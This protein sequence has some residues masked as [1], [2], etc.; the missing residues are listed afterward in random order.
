M[1][2]R[3]AVPTLSPAALVL[4]CCAL[5]SP[6]LAQTG[7]RAPAGPAAVPGWPSATPSATPP[8]PGTVPDASAGGSSVAS[9]Q[10]PATT[11]DAFSAEVAVADRGPAER[12]AAYAAALR[13][14][15]L[16]NSA[17]RTLMN[18]DDVRA[19]LRDA[20]SRVE[21][22]RFRTPE[23]GS[24]IPP[25][26][27]VTDA[28][29]R[30]GEAVGLLRIRFDRERTL[31]L[32]AG[33]P[34]GAE[35]PAATGPLVA[36]PL[37]DGSPVDPAAVARAFADVDSALV[38]LV[39]EDGE[40]VIAGSEPAAAKV[41]ERVR[42]I[43]GGAGATVVFGDAADLDPGAVRGLDAAAI[44]AASTRYAT[45][46]VLVGRLARGGAASGAPVIGDAP[47]GFTERPDAAPGIDLRDRSASGGLGT[48][49]T[50]MATR[51]DRNGRRM[52]ERAASE[53]ATGWRGDWLKLGALFEPAADVADASGAAGADAASAVPGSVGGPVAGPVVA[54]T[55]TAGARLDDALRAGLEWLLPDALGGAGASYAYG[56]RGDATEGVVWVGSID[57]VAEYA[58]IMSLFESVASVENVFPRAIGDGNGTFAVRPRR[59][60]QEL[61]S[62]AAA[63]GWLRPGSPPLAPPTVAGP[64]RGTASG[65]RRGESAGASETLAR[66]ADL[67]FDATL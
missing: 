36:D 9:T 23:P 31:A 49:I 35:A 56:G 3:H 6:V 18:R 58:R 25:D 41:R 8:A 64:E 30:S 16:A 50:D 5:A 55:A 22:F 20:G 11:L 52:P 67:A 29:R 39:I 32:L 53:R 12:D 27:P 63:A 17:D 57:S 24:A 44:A 33:E 7:D 28:V 51:P 38:W 66:Q 47:G 43:A 4:A 54:R 42:E 65:A 26:T 59:A 2:I 34:D 10:A 13:R 46:A 15:L 37:P 61:A 19:A 14:V 45:D 21:T 40:R 62:V 48:D 1:R 60:L